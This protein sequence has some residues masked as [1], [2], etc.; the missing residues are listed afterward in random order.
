MIQEIDQ[1]IRAEANK[2]ADFLMFSQR[3]FL[4]N[5]SHA[6]ND[7]Q[8]SY[9]QLFLLTYL[10]SQEHLT[11]SEI[12]KKMGHS[13]AAATGLVDR[14][15]KLGYVSRNHA[16]DDR[17]KVMVQIT[18]KGTRLVNAIRGEI[19]SDIV[20]LLSQPGDRQVEEIPSIS[21]DLAPHAPQKR[22]RVTA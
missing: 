19:Y 16:E 10:T 22:R 9:A 7:G 18:N 15:E 17:R 6:L 21:E 13:T 5:L 8:V 14:L 2:L 12:A 3:T 1:P 4:L 20:D 11:M